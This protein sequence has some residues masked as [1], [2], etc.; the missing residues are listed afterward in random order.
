MYR[1]I[2]FLLFWVS[3][4]SFAQQNVN[5]SEG[6]VF[7]GEP[8]I[9]YNDKVPGQ[10]VVA[11]MG[12]KFNNQLVVKYRFSNDYGTTWSETKFIPHVHSDYTSAD[13]SMAID[14]DG[15]IYLCYI[16]HS[17]DLDSGGVY[18]VYTDDEGNTLST[19][20]KAI[21]AYDVPGEYPVD[22]PWIAID[23]VGTGIYITVK[24][25]YW[26]ELPNR[27]YYIRGDYETWSW[28]TLKPLDGGGLETGN[29]I[30]NPVASPCVSSIGRF[31]AI[32]PSYLPSTYV[33]P[34][35]VLAKLEANG[36]LFYSPVCDVA[37]PVT[38]TLAKRG[39]NLC[40]DPTDSCRLAFIFEQEIYGDAD[41]FYTESNDCGENWTEPVR[42]NDDEQG[43]EKMQ[44]LAWGSFN[45]KGD[46]VAVWRDR[47]N[48]TDGYQS[49]FDIYCAFK[50][51][52]SAD[53]SANVKINDVT[54][55]FDTIL[56]KNGNDFLSVTYRKD[57]V[58]AVWGDVRTGSLNIFFTKVNAKNLS[59]QTQ[60]LATE[61]LPLFYPNPAKKYLYVN[62]T[63]VVTKVKIYDTVGKLVAEKEI[64][65]KVLDISFL[66]KGIYFFEAENKKQKVVV[67]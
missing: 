64:K 34:R 13:P 53:F 10:L 19:P 50:Y 35:Y 32:Y 49:D 36:S 59:N 60:I 48:G 43:N 18:V 5:I 31:F 33:Y 25:V 3:I 46:F 9:L 39:T 42:I 38:D 30:S 20:Y 61:Q 14:K 51:K 8:Y 65:G 15:R 29:Y 63:V 44:D 37:S 22:R 27:P 1:L 11:W 12:Y 7:D 66:K 58:Y 56:N 24:P 52:D 23:T 28:D 45:E 6:Y 47:R 41:V 40:I 16:D 57:T 2:L 62:N 4:K 55:P 26:D 21:D 17:Q 54:L 67:E